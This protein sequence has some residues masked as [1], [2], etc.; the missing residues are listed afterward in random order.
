MLTRFISDKSYET[1]DIT[2]PHDSNIKMDNVRIGVDGNLE[3][4]ITPILSNIKDLKINKYVLNILSKNDKLSNIINLE[5]NNI[6]NNK[7]CRFYYNN[8]NVID[9]NTLFWKFETNSVSVSTHYTFSDYDNFFEMD[10]IDD[11]K[12][13]IYHTENF[14]KY[15]LTYSLAL[16][17]VKFIPLTAKNFENYTTDLNYSLTDNKIILYVENNLGNFVINKKIE[18]LFISTNTLLSSD[19]FFYIQ[20]ISELNSI[21]NSNNWVSYVDEYNFNKQNLHVNTS[22]S[23]FNIP[24]N[25]LLTTTINSISS[26]LP[27][28]ILT[29]KN[30][31]NQENDQSRGNVFLNENET[32]LKEYESIFTGGYRELGYNEINLGY[33]SYSTPFLFKSGKTTY[34]HVPHDIYPYEK[35]NVNSSKLVESGAVGGNSP[36]NS[37]KIW[38]KLK[39]YRDTSPYANPQEEQTGQWLCTWLS[40]GN[41]DARPIWMDR[42][43]KPYKMTAFEALSATVNEAIY[44]DSFNCL[45][46]KDGV[47]DVKSSITFEKGSYYAYMHLGKNDYYNLINES[48]SAKIYYTDLNQYKRTNFDDLESIN[49]IHSFDGKTFGYIESNKNF[50]HNVASFSFFAEKEN[51]ENPSGNMIFGNYINKGFAFYNYVLNTPYQIL[52]LNDN[53]LQI[54]NNNFSEIDKLSTENITLCG[55]AGVSRRNGFENIHIITKDFRLIEIDLKGTIVDSNSTLIE[56]LSLKASDEIY[57]ITN[58]KNNCYVHTSS[59]V[60]EIDLNSN[61]IL[62]KDIH[63]NISTSYTGSSSIVVD[64]NEMIYLFHAR[65]PIYKNGVIYGMDDTNKLFS[66][67]TTLSTLSTHIKTEGNI[68]CFNVDSD[69]HINIVTSG[70]ILYSY[71]NNVLKNT[72]TLPL[73]STYSLSAQKFNFCEKFEYGKLKKYKQLYCD[74]QT[75]SAAYILQI[76]EDD[77]QKLIKL[78]EKYRIIQDNLDLTGYNFNQAYLREEFDPKSYNFR[79]KLLNRVNDEDYYELVFNIDGEDLSSGSRHFFFNIDCYN[80]EANFYLDG[81]LY[82]RIKFESK[83]YTLTKTF[84]GR[85]YYGANGYHN[86]NTVFKYFKDVSDFTYSDLK[87]SNIYI[88]NKSLDRFQALYFYNLIYPPDDLKYNMPSGTRSFIDKLEKTFNFNIPMF[89]SNHFNLKILNSGISDESARIHIENMIKDKV[90]EYLPNYTKLNNFEWLDHKSENLTIKGDYNVSNTLTDLV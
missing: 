36:L 55:I 32:T 81:E 48:I 89:K 31:L 3:Y 28:N 29:L 59:G 2:Y 65:Q 85:I 17:T 54:L 39:D 8:E 82:E 33:T 23:N 66:Y 64:N 20:P 50:E 70:N 72:M 7:L 4:T 21:K 62:P 14:L 88:M 74:N 73:L 18:K 51:W 79:V 83:K 5:Q 38:K 52:K 1:V 57:S 46:L 77:N 13:R 9:E 47:S 24:N 37:D 87:I 63:Y 42:Y 19:N 86:G 30:Q 90:L 10:F 76:D 60:A 68:L 44:I 49:G 53:T 40:A 22:R 27:I 11:N 84:N 78:N 41:P 58:D 34:F 15:T 69:D 45:D 25:F 26:S 43:Y 71:D 61:L 12:C 67:S 75:T 56:T 6:V 16:G 80:G 35:L